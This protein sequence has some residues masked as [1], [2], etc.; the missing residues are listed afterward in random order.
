LFPS[1]QLIRPSPR[2]HSRSQLAPERC[3]LPA[4]VWTRARVRHHGRRARGQGGDGHR[5]RSRRSRGHV[6]QPAAGVR[7]GQRLEEARR[8]SRRWTRGN[9]HGDPTTLLCQEGPGTTPSNGVG[10]DR[11]APSLGGGHPTGWS[12]RPRPPSASKRQ[13]AGRSR[14]A[15]RDA[16]SWSPPQPTA[17][18][19]R[20]GLQ[21]APCGESG[22]PAAS[23]H[24]LSVQDTSVDLDPDPA[25][26][27]S[28]RPSGRL[29]PAGRAQQGLRVDS[30]HRSDSP[31]A[32]QLPEPAVKLRLPPVAPPEPRTGGVVS[33]SSTADPRVQGPRGSGSSRDNLRRRRERPLGGMSRKEH[34][35]APGGG[36]PGRRQ[37]RVDQDSTWAGAIR[38]SRTTGKRSPQHWTILPSAIR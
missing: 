23:G 24:V 6:H 38:A 10:L 28:V 16:R 31:V 20:R 19:A 33:P 3:S 34:A 2:S 30:A 37:N 12:T 17:A 13:P 9:S 22:A 8:R 4:A 27:T 15:R 1:C 5:R 29:A 14:S 36:A 25:D 32:H 26:R 7:S 35:E 21:K 11:R 18:Q